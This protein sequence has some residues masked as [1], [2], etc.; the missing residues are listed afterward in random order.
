MIGQTVGP[1]LHNIADTHGAFNYSQKSKVTDEASRMTLSLA[2]KLLFNE[3]TGI[4]Y[5]GKVVSRHFFILYCDAKAVLNEQDEFD[6]SLRIDYTA[7]QRRIISE[8]FA[9]A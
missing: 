2:V 3:G 8:C 4:L 6:H 7:Q 1:R 9:A 5:R